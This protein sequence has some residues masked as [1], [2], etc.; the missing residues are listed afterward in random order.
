[1]KKRLLALVIALLLLMGA[2]TAFSADATSPENGPEVKSYVPADGSCAY[3]LVDETPYV[4]TK[5]E[6]R[7]LV[8]YGSLH[9]WLKID[10]SY[11]IEC[12]IPVQTAE[13]TATPTA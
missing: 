5:A 10:G 1:M 9:I 8:E 4:V 6:G 7:K 3:F 2:V 12:P 13:P 11:T